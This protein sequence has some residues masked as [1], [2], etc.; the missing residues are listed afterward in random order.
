MK[1]TEEIKKITEL[2]DNIVHEEVKRKTC[3]SLSPDMREFLQWMLE[4][5]L[6]QTPSD[7]VT[8]FYN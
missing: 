3:I 4:D 6:D 8:Y 5:E 2:I 1:H 7:K